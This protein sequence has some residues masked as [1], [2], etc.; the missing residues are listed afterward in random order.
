MKVSKSKSK[1]S[2]ALNYFVKK[3]AIG[4]LIG[5]VMISSTL[6]ITPDLVAHA[7]STN[8]NNNTVGYEQVAKTVASQPFKDVQT[9]HYA[10]EAI[11]WG[12]N[13]GLISGYGNGLFGPNDNV[14]E[15]QFVKMVSSYLGLK[16]TSGNL[17]KNNGQGSHWSD[18]HYDAMAKHGVPLN[19][20]FDNSIRNSPMKRG[21]VA[22]ALAYL[23]GDETDLTESINF[24][25]DTGITSGQNPQFKGKD[26]YKFFGTTNNL[27]RGQV[28][29]FLYR[30]DSKGMNNLSSMADGT[31]SYEQDLNSKAKEGYSYVDVSLGG[32]KPS[33]NNN[34]NNKVE[35]LKSLFTVDFLYESIGPTATKLLKADGYTYEIYSKNGIGSYYMYTDNEEI[36]VKLN[37]EGKVMTTSSQSIHYSKD[38]MPILNAIIGLKA[39]TL[40]GTN[41]EHGKIVNGYR[42]SSSFGVYSLNNDKLLSEYVE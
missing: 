16:D 29:T 14:T 32:K 10:Y 40:K 4:S 2:S 3:T 5:V 23:L 27:T 12:K 24:L 1:F 33:V 13:K 22:Q 37:T 30:M 34:T 38:T 20:Y 11:N 39:G 17:K 18:T 28:I 19:G 6:M 8:V 36:T 26:L 25:L 9:S 15:S 7:N 42:V 35:D 31:G 21:S 41:A